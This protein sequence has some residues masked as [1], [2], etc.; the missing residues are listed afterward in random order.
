[1]AMDPVLCFPPSM[2]VMGITRL[3]GKSNL[4]SSKPHRTS[5]YNSMLGHHP[6][7]QYTNDP[8]APLLHRHLVSKN[9][10]QPVTE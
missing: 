1:M 3:D 5:Q 10:L 4:L 6:K 7:E 9:S 2:F 8:P